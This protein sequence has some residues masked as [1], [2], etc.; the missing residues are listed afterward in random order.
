MLKAFY[1]VF[2]YAG[3][4]LLL[5]SGCVDQS[6]E[7]IEPVIPYYQ[8]TAEDRT[9]LNIK[10][11]DS[12]IFENARG[13]QQRYVVRSVEENIKTA[14]YKSPFTGS[15]LV[16]YYHDSQEIEIS[17]VD[18]V[19]RDHLYFRRSMPLE[20]TSNPEPP[21]G[22]GEFL[23]QGGW[24]DYIGEANPPYALGIYEGV[25]NFPRF[26]STTSVKLMNLAVRG[27]IYSSVLLLET[28]R[29]PNACSYCVP[30]KMRTLNQIYYD[31]QY[32]IVR[33]KSTIT[34]EVWNRVL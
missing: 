6:E 21:S 4:L 19:G 27:H 11:G 13:Q 18:S 31:K 23:I 17:R 10:K 9:W 2:R 34:G 33:M 26:K 20:A 15:R 29:V 24:T 12:W 8:F 32:G 7:Y 5:N 30:K 28:S 25:L 22:L 3:V 16:D 14:S 1:S